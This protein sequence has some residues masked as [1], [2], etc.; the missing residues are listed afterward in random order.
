MSLEENIEQ[1]RPDKELDKGSAGIR[2]DRGAMSHPDS[3]ASR[4]GKIPPHSPQE[5]A[6][7]NEI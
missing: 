5:A 3:E 6:K 1:G 7:R 4:T 2:I